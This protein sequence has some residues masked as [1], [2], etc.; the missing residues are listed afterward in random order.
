MWYFRPLLILGG[1]TA[2]FLAVVIF[3][4]QMFQ[5]GHI[6]LTVDLEY[7][8]K[9]LTI[10]GSVN[11]PNRSI[12][13]YEVAPTDEAL[14]KEEGVYASGI[15]LVKN[16]EYYTTIDTSLIPPGEVTVWARF[17]ITLSQ[18][19]GIQARYGLHGE[20]LRGSDLKKDSKDQWIEVSKS[21]NID[22]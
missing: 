5:N 11:L 21:I 12:I 4:I 15:I 17:I 3:A 1:I 18:P 19:P 8:P 6:G 20:E 7:Q 22:S 14:F 10:K 16:G 2:V 13:A 9:A